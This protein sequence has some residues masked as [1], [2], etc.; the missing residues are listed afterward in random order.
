MCPG[1]SNIFWTMHTWEEVENNTFCVVYDIFR[2]RP[3][4]IMSAGIISLIVTWRNCIQTHFGWIHT[5][6]PSWRSGSRSLCF[7][8]HITIFTELKTALGWGRRG[9][10]NPHVLLQLLGFPWL[11]RLHTLLCPWWSQLTPV[12]PQHT[13]PLSQCPFQS[14]G[15]MLDALVCNLLS[16]E[17]RPLFTSV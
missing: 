16:T 6:G 10:T 9:A 13:C 5:A 8:W 15:A 7:V 11:E 2:G 3:L 12:G 14:L 1:G 17:L 4:C